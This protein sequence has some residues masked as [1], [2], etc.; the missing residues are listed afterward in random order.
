MYSVTLSPLSVSSVVYRSVRLVRSLLFLSQLFRSLPQLRILSLPLLLRPW[1]L[2]SFL[3]SGGSPSTPPLA[4][5]S[6]LTA[7]TL[8]WKIATLLRDFLLF[9]LFIGACRFPLLVRPYN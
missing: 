7:P 6:A 9:L 5:S 8:R 1:S 2:L 3:V 4:S